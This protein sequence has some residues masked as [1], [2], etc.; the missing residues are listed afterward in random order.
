MPHACNGSVTMQQ[1]FFSNSFFIVVFGCATHMFVS[2]FFHLQF[3]SKIKCIHSFIC[4]HTWVGFFLPFIHTRAHSE[5]TPIYHNHTNSS[6]IY[7]CSCSIYWGVAHGMMQIS[8]LLFTVAAATAA[9]L[10]IFLLLKNHKL[11]YMKCINIFEILIPCF[12]LHR[13]SVGSANL[14]VLYLFFFGF[15]LFVSRNLTMYIYIYIYTCV[16]FCSYA[17]GCKFVWF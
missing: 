2:L 17:V 12:V 14:N 3:V 9:T 10:S 11:N 1:H 15:H 16:C 5:W 7:I 8:S 6:L 4:I 13:I